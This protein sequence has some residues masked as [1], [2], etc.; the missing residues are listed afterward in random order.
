MIVKTD[1]K[2]KNIVTDKTGKG[3]NSIR[4]ISTSDLLKEKLRKKYGEGERFGWL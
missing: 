4:I 1:E 2:M 3:F